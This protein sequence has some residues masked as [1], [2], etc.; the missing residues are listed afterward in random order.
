MDK[1]DWTKKYPVI[2]LDFTELDY[3]TSEQL[4]LSLDKFLDDTAKRENISLE[5]TKTRLISSKF[6]ELIKKLHGSTGQQVVL[7]IDEYDKPM[8]D[9][10]NKAKELHQLIKETLHNF[11]QVIKSTDTYLK[12]VFM[13]G[14]SRFAGLSVF[15]A[16]NNLRDITMNNKLFYYLWI[17]SRRA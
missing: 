13:T 4:E 9:S 6:S 14:V 17:Y 15:S 3:T 10:L 7:L 8:I 12:F 2:H 5:Q 1:W 16:L 11:Y